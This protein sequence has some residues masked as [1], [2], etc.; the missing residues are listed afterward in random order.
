M[1]AEQEKAAEQLQCE[2]VDAIEDSEE[3]VIAAIKDMVGG[4]ESLKPKRWSMTAKLQELQAK[5]VKLLEV[6]GDGSFG[7][8]WKGTFQQQLVAVKKLKYVSALDSRSIELFKR[9]AA[10]MQNLNH[11]YI[12]HLWGM[13]MDPAN[14]FICVEFA[15]GG[16]LK[17]F[18]H[19]NHGV[20]PTDHLVALYQNITSALE[21]T[22]ARGIYH[23]DI[24]PEN[25]L[26][27]ICPSALSG[28]TAKLTDFGLSKFKDTGGSST[29]GGG[30][31]GTYPYIAPEVL[32]ID[33]E[34]DEKA[35]TEKRERM[36]WC[37][38]DV[39]ALGVLGFE[40]FSRVVPFQGLTIRSIFRRV[41]DEQERPGEIPASAP[42]A[43][44]EVI[45]CAWAQ[46]AKDRPNAAQVN[47][48]LTAE[49]SR[50]AAAA[51]RPPPPPSSSRSPF[52]VSW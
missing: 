4:A 3:R 36:D 22:H 14:A 31:I 52:E 30:A 2:L 51:P 41:V 33:D 10:I 1:A 35:R 17:D 49:V 23:R 11:P 6:V 37:K 50:A 34:D 25:V 44:K 26:L 19:K 8:V 43:I 40:M 20:F 46:N 38:V 24:K 28:F 32:E 18:L 21:F 42:D 45:R 16:T 48:V 39:Y 27:F 12:V 13:G 5:D 29:V 7:Q 9:E 47:N 15:E